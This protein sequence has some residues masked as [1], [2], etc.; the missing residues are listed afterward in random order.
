MPGYVA[1]GSI[2]EVGPRK[3]HVRVPPVSDQIADVAGGPFGADT[4]EKVPSSS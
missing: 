4:V 3:R 2:S 1:D